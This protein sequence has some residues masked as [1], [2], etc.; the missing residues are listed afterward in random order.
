MIWKIVRQIARNGIRTEPA[1]GSS[2]GVRTEAARIQDDV[3]SVRSVWLRVNRIVAAITAPALE[4]LML[5]TP[6]VVH[7]VLRRCIKD[8]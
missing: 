7:V 4:G 1:P 8:P 2:D 3:S 6:D 5:L